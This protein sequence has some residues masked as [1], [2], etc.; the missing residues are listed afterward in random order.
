MEAVQR[1]LKSVEASYGD[2]M[3]HL[4]IASGYLSKLLSRK[5]IKRYL[6]SHHPEIA[7][8]FSAIV[9]ATPLDHT[10]HG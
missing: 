9:K 1:D 6:D 8:E 3:L 10:T 2:D 7:A 4:V 5:T